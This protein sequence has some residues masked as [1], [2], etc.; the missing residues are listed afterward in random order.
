VTPIWGNATSSLGVDKFTVGRS[1]YDVLV[2][3][4]PVRAIDAT[5]RPGL[6]LVAATPC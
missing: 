6:D 5:N 1:I 4:L 3:G 2:D